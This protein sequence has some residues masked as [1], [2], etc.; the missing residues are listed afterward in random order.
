MSTGARSR[1]WRTGQSV[2]AT[3]SLASSGA[4]ASPA[5][6]R[7]SWSRFQRAIPMLVLAP[8]W[9]ALVAGGLLMLIAP[10]VMWGLAP[11]AVFT[12]VGGI[13]GFAGGWLLLG[14]GIRPGGRSEWGMLA[15]AII[16]IYVGLIWA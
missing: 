2:L 14:A 10:T 4:P 15:A 16:Y 12:A 13:L 8:H 6:S 1:F 7:V 9:P 5:A 11:R 3:F